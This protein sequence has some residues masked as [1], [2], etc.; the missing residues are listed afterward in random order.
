MNQLTINARIATILAG[1]QTDLRALLLEAAKGF[2]GQTLEVILEN[3]QP[4]IVNS[5]SGSITIG[6]QGVQKIEH[7]LTLLYAV[8][9]A[10]GSQNVATPAVA[11][12]AAPSTAAPA[13]AV[14]ATAEA[15]AAVSV[16]DA[17]VAPSAAA[18]AAEEVKAG[19]E[20]PSIVKNEEMDVHLRGHGA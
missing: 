4:A 19:V 11:A 18:L 5:T 14:A 6:G 1:T 12:V 17:H 2:E 9:R 16:T 10:V 3:D 7:L 8:Q 20:P 15:P 13:P